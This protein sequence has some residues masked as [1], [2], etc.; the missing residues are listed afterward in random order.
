MLSSL[1]VRWSCSLARSERAVK[2]ARHHECASSLSPSSVATLEFLSHISE[3]DSVCLHNFGG[4]KITMRWQNLHSLLNIILI[5]KIHIVS[6][7]LERLN[8]D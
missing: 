6:H 4:L 2:A 7:E 5:T 3:K 1:E 8:K